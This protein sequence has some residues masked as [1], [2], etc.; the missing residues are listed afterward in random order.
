MVTNLSIKNFQEEQSIDQV[1]FLPIKNLGFG[2]THFNKLHT[3]ISKWLPIVLW[4]LLTLPTET[5]TPGIDHLVLGLAWLAIIFLAV[6][7]QTS[8]MEDKPG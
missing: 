4:W 7:T 8:F 6:Y 3:C 1:W 5:F 2:R